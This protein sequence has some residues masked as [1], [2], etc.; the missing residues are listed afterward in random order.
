[1]PAGLLFLD[2]GGEK[3]TP[4]LS[5]GLHFWVSLYN[6]WHRHCSAGFILGRYSAFVLNPST[7]FIFKLKHPDVFS[8]II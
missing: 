1:L 3:S 6:Y 7:A 2:G 5:K 4:E 8:L